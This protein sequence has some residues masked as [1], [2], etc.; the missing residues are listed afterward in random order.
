[1]F[2]VDAFW[3][4]TFTKTECESW[5]EALKLAELTAS[6]GCEI[7]DIINTEIKGTSGVIKTIC[8]S[9]QSS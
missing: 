8:K 9:S 6:F 3:D 2:R 4:H 5:S 7:V 1:M